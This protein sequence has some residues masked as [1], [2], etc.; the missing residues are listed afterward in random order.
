MDD[1]IKR[2]Q[3]SSDIYLQRVS[4]VGWHRVKTW[5][6]VMGGGGSQQACDH[7]A[8][9]PTFVDAF[10]R[11]S[12]TAAASTRTRPR[13]GN[14]SDPQLDEPHENAQVYHLERPPPSPVIDGDSANQFEL[15]RKT[16]CMSVKR[17]ASDFNRVLNLLLPA[18]NAAVTGA[19]STKSSRHSVIPNLRTLLV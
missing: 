15:Q 2:G 3:K 12:P 9:A 13:R 16:W 10:A 19:F 11:R 14:C 1:L 7:P 18:I 8:D 17:A 6:T 5:S 4:A